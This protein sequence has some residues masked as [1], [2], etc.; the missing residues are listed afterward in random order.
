[1]N[2][3]YSEFSDFKTKSQLCRKVP[4]DFNDDDIMDLMGIRSEFYLNSK[5]KENQFKEKVL[6]RI[7]VETTKGIVDM[8]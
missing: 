2:Y 7:M 6:K 3:S 4:H 1:M 8:K 5:M